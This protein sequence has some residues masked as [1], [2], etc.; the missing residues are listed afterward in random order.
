MGEKGFTL[1]ETIIYVAITGLVLAGFVVFAFSISGSRDKSYVISEVGANS[2][3]ALDVISQRIRNAKEVNVSSIFDSDPGVL[4]LE[5][6]DPSKNPTIINLNQNDGVLQIVEGTTA[7]AAVTSD[8]VKI[9]NLVFNNLTSGSE[10]ENIR[11][12][13]TVEFN[14]LS[15]DVDYNYSQSF[16]TAVSLRQ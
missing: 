13:L 2:R 4:S 5:M 15:G 3:M 6:A 12:I 11:V 8:E 1:I 7:P 16:Q 14:N 9:T 10:R